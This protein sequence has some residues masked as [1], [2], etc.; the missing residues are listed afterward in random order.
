MSSSYQ[1]LLNGQ[2]AD[3]SLY[4]L[5]ASVEVEE[6][7]DLPGAVQIQL[8]ISRDTN[9]DLT[10]VADPQFAPFSTIAVV[11]TAGGAGVAGAVG[12][13]AGDVAAA[14]ADGAAAPAAQCIFDGYLLSQK[15][16]LETGT[17]NSTLTV[18]GQDA[19]W[20]MNTAERVK[21]WVDVTDADVASAIFADYGIT[22][23]DANMDD[24]SA[25]HTEDG[26]SLM[27]RGSD[28]QFLRMLARRNGKVCRVACADQPGVRTGYFAKPA[29]DGDPAVTLALNDP[30]NWTVR[31]LDIE[32][33]ATRPSAVVA[34]Q[35]LFSDA[36]EDG[37]SGDAD[38][39]GLTLLGDSGLA[40]FTGQAV[41]VLL[42]TPV[43][44]AGELSQRARAVLR[45]TN[46]FVR[47][48]GEA[49]VDRLGVVLRAGM[50]VALAGIGAV[51][52]GNY[53]IWSVRHRITPEAHSMKFV[54]LRNAVGAAP[55]GGAG[56]LAVLVGA[57]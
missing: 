41:T 18:W 31:A 35:A 39:S 37:A 34:R 57:A 47:C 51:H 12:G 43:D 53:L 52:S 55:A 5:I 6:S 7:M 8:P 16:H 19:S 11:A 14:L 33:D 56:G 44:D 9:G 21:E 49:D 26:H 42:T 46:W 30:T 27:Q 22:P 2:P 29:L 23:A 25:T 4:T 1:I 13:A 28:I 17:T 50:I 45:D 10:F 32:W 3:P 20:L 36:D 38:D 48:E 54:L 24:D 15:I 40:D